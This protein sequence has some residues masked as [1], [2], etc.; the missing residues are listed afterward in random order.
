VIVRLY[1]GLGGRGRAGVRPRIPL[2]G[3]EVVDLLERPLDGTVTPLDGHGSYTVD[4][5]PFQVVTLRL[6]RMDGE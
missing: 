4:L 2:R 3:V 1:E 6:H 5:H